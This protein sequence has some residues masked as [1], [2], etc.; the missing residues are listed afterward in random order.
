MGMNN[1]AH[2]VSVVGITGYAGQE[3]ERLLASHPG[4]GIAGRFAS[5]ADEKSGAEAFSMEKLRSSS[6]DVV[7]LATEH[8]L[9]MH[10]VP[11]LLNDGYRVVDMSGAFRMKDAQL[12][13]QWYGF[14]HAVPTL[15]KEAIYGMPEY[16]ADSIRNARL[17]ANPGCYATAAILPLAP[18]YKAKA[19]DPAS[20]VV[21]DGKSGVSGA[22]RQPKQHT[23]FCEVNENLSAYGI[24]QH[25]H[26]PEMIAYIP[27]AA[28]DRFVFTPHL[29]PITRGILNTIVLRTPDRVS[30][31]SILAETYAK[32]PF[33]RVLPEG[34]LPDVRSVARTNFCSIGVVTKGSNTVIVSAIDNLVKG[35]SGQAIQNLNLMLGYDQ[36]VGLS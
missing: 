25:R 33:V 22:G 23:H 3:L 7:V 36:A 24:L 21:V 4:I 12:Y 30:V 19:I 29:I 15:L 8:E 2:H 26:T 1:Y 35:A 18:L 13:P 14:E 16:F 5:K 31:R 28:V 6:P 11:E 9:S 32:E 34:Q 17:V 27:G 10:M 20:V